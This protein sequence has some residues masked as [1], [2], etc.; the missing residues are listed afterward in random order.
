MKNI[1]IWILLLV[2]LVSGAWF[3]LANNINDSNKNSSDSGKAP[4][5]TNT[6]GIDLGVDNQEKEEEGFVS[7]TNEILSF[8]HPKDLNCST[9]TIHIDHP[10]WY[11]TL[12]IDAENS[13]SNPTVVIG[14]PYVDSG[15]YDD[16]FIIL[17]EATETIDGRLVHMNVYQ[18]KVN[19]S[20]HTV[21]YVVGNSEEE[22]SF[23]IT[24][25]LR[26]DEGQTL[27]SSKELGRD[28]LE[29]FTVGS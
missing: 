29:S 15:E 28:I 10:D 18:S 19:K 24:L 14:T 8:K 22:K 20:Y 21:N 26:L 5:L 9:R 25:P 27:E 2:V 4:E 1:I 6:N 12:C 16:I 3:L 17:E 7:Y 11:Q 23:S 13:F